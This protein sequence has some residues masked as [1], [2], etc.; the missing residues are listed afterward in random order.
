M[1]TVFARM[2]LLFIGIVILSTGIVLITKSSLGTSPISSFSYVLSI[3][4][5]SISYGTFLFAWNCLLIIGQLIILRSSFRPI[6]LL[7]IPIALVSSIV[8]DE[9]S[10]V[11]SWYT[12]LNYA[13][14]LFLLA[15]GIIVMAIG[16]ACMV[17]ANIATG[18]GEAFVGAIASKAHWNFGRTK[19][20]FDLLCVALAVGA[21]FLLTGGLYG[22][23]EGT[24]IAA[25]V[26]GLFVNV[27][28]KELGGIRP[29]IDEILASVTPARRRHRHR[30]ARTLHR[31]P[32]GMRLALHIR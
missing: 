16:A 3:S 25:S 12:P 28:I 4:C 2:C 11:I 18:S 10:Q 20:L 31:L 8:V 26:T 27:F 6:A 29:P 22:V 23:R 19:V 13:D 7:Q 17:T 5:P 32:H 15:L 1:K 14:S 9:F 21:S 24:I 30:V